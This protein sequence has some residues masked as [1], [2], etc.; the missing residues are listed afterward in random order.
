[1]DGWCG[2]I[3]GEGREAGREGEGVG[4]GEIGRDDEG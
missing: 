2:Q 3:E 4:E 1:M